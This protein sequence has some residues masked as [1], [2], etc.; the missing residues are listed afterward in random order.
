MRGS[1]M[2][3]AILTGRLLR[4]DMRDTSFILIMVSKTA[5]PTSPVA[6]VKMRCIFCPLASEKAIDYEDTKIGLGALERD[7]RRLL[8]NWNER[9]AASHT[10]GDECVL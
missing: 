6:P 1:L 7:L 5:E 4:M 3:S 2:S 10:I 8:D 9:R